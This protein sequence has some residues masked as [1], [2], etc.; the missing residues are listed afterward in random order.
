M[1]N[2][3][4]WVWTREPTKPNSSG[5]ITWA[6]I[7][8]RRFGG[9]FFFIFFKP[10]MLEIILS[11]GVKRQLTLGFGFLPT[12]NVDLILAEFRTREGFLV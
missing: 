3:C 5:S 1:Y 10:L 9:I 8:R 11:Q 6:L 12:M 4:I 2:D 7:I